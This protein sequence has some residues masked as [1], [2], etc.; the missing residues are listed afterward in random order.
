MLVNNAGLFLQRRQVTGEGLEL[1]FATNH[2]SMFLLTGCSATCWS[3][4]HR[5]GS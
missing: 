3:R 4:A 5:R 1:T 2:L